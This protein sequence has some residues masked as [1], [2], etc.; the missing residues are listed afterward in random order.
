MVHVQLDDLVDESA[1]CDFLQYEGGMIVSRTVG[2]R[3]VCQ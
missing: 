1:N 2:R 3:V